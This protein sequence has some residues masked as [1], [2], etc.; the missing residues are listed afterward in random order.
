MI[1]IDTSVLVAYHNKKDVHHKRATEIIKKAVDGMYGEVYITDYI[2]DECATVLFA[3]LGDLAETVKAGT[4][5]KE[6]ERIVIEYEIFEEAWHLF[7]HQKQT[8]FSFTDC[9]TLAIINA[10]G[11]THLA[12]FDTDF[13]E[14]EGI[15][16]VC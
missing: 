13:K 7:Q 1:L 2:F 10:Y 14:T 5:I 9:S 15:T 12:T 16:C 6:V 4:E 3:R 8:K 11:I